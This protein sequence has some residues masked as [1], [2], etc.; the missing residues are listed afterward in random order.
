MVA[1]FAFACTTQDR[2][3]SYRSFASRLRGV[4][5]TWEFHETCA[6]CGHVVDDSESRVSN[7]L[8]IGM[9]DPDTQKDLMEEATK[10]MTV[11]QTLHLVEKKATR[12]RAATALK[13]PTTPSTNA[14]DKGADWEEAVNSGYK[15]QQQRRPQS[16]AEPK[17]LTNRPQ[18]TLPK[19]MDKG[20]CNFCRWRGHGTSSRTAIRRLSAQHMARHASH[21]A[22]P[23]TSHNCAGRPWSWRAQYTR[24]SMI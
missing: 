23:T 2:G 17:P 19:T 12:K 6:N 7:Q 15:R 4:A 11:E 22:A 5:E 10:W 18:A 9:A 3:E 20:T 1:T 13:E 24:Q 16:H 21:A 14:L 8:C